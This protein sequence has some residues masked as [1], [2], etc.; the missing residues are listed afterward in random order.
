MFMAQKSF[1]PLGALL[2]LALALTL[3]PASNHALAGESQL[4]SEVDVDVTGKDAAD[5]RERAME[6]AQLDGLVDLLSKLTSPDQVQLITTNMDPKR[7][8]SMVRG[9]EVLDEK[10]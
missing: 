9:T 1:R 5:A 3:F 2:A 8:A 6:K 7:L 4:N 10:I